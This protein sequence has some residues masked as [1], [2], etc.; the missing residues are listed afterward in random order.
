MVIDRRQLLAAMLAGLCV[1]GT[2]RA[3]RID[4]RLFVS[5]RLDAANTASVC[6]FDENGTDLFSTVLPARGHDITTR[7]RHREVVAF[8]RRPGNWFVAASLDDGA[9]R[10]V[11]HSPEGRHLYG[12]GVFT[13][14]GRRLYVTENDMATGAGIIGV[15]D[16][17]AGYVRT[18]E[19]PSG[20]I[21]P[22]DLTL[23]PDGHTLV[24]A[25]GGLRTHPD[26][27]RE[28]LNPDDMQPNLAVID[29]RDRRIVSV[30]E[31]D[32]SLHQLSIRHLALRQDGLV[33]FGCQ[34]EGGTDDMPQLVG[35]LT[36]GGRIA[37][38]DI[39]EDALFRMK[40]YV[41][42]VSFN[43]DGSRL[44]A[45]SPRGGAALIWN[46]TENRLGRSVAIPDVCGAAPL[47]S[48]HFLVTS[49]NAGVRPLGFSADDAGVQPHAMNWI[50]DNH[51]LAIT[52][53]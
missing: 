4:R 19:F 52:P 28:T 24:V 16:A 32:A 39:D 48:G 44:I 17:D 22:H 51:A 47:D 26:T 37:L 50:W 12:H 53:A 3:A 14:D 29:L 11:V 34:Y 38:L 21:G 33:A 15:Y 18:G 13:D 42:S 5:C 23:M 1:S 25:N 46:M 6:C 40:N 9:V 45:T 2:A 27:G 31:L 30:A 41:G 8:A 49:G 20:G 35:T 36:P 10:A 43:D 7:P